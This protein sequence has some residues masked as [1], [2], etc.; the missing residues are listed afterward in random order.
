VPTEPDIT[1]KLFQLALRIRSELRE[2]IDQQRIRMS[3]NDAMA[4][5]AVLAVIVGLIAGSISICFRLL[6]TGAL[7]SSVMDDYSA[8]FE[9][10][11]GATRFLLCAGGG[12]VIGLIFQSVSVSTRQ[13]GIVHV[14]ERLAYHHGRLPLKNA[15]MQFVGA[16]LC[17][18]TGQ[19]VG[20]EGPAVHLGAAAGANISDVLK[21]PHNAGRILIGCGVASAIGAGFNTPLAG[22]IFAMEVVLMEYTILGFTPVIIASLTA[23]SLARIVFGDAPAFSVPSI[24]WT[25]VGE[26]PYVMLMG[27]VIGLSAAAFVKASV[28]FSHL[29]ET[30]PVWIR[31]AV[32]GTITGALAI[33]APQIMGIGYDTLSLAIVG[34]ISMAALM[35]IFFA[36]IVATSAAV[37]LGMPGGLIAPSLLMGACLG[38]SMGMMANDLVSGL[39]DEG[40]YALLGA[41]AM[42]GATLHAPLAALVAILELSGTHSVILPAM[43]AVVAALITKRVPFGF[44]SIY[45]VLMRERGLDYRNAPMAQALRRI[46]VASVMDKSVSQMDRIITV[47]AA[48][49]ALEANQR[50]IMAFADKGQASLLPAADLAIHLSNLK[51]DNADID[52]LSLPAM[53]EDS[54]RITILETLQEAHEAMEATGAE[55][56]YVTGAHG[57]SA[58]RIYGVITREHIERHYKL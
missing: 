28:V 21:I 14:L 37:G 27:I 35:L 45:R 16:A 4:Q 56:L 55:L 50:W 13:T 24:E 34:Q 31:I 41:C 47:D 17:M 1:Q 19:S 9:S 29:F 44:M 15:A 48:R 5:L 43:I 46:G 30:K 12:V 40:L 33:P 20:R 6:V 57:K 49:K 3:R 36:K 18:I 32:A 53:R 42:M 11:S 23:T 52:L 10:L 26:L 39:H 22:V 25:S 7:T 8:S 54:T 38:G 51:S 58:N 2:F